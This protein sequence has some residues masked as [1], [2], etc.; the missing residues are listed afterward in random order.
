MYFIPKIEKVL[1][2]VCLSLFGLSVF[3][4]EAKSFS[5]GLLVEG[6]AN[7][8]L[9][10]GLA[11]GVIGEYSFTNHIAAG[12]K[13]D[14]GTDFNDV[15]VSSAELLGFGRYYF[16]TASRVSFF[17]QV[18]AGAIA[19]FEGNKRAYSVLGDG[20]LGIRIRIKN[21]YTDPYVRFGWPTG[22]GFGIAIGYRFGVK[23]PSEEEVQVVYLPPPV[24]QEPVEEDIPNQLEVFFIGNASTFEIIGNGGLDI[25]MENMAKLSI[26]A[27]FL[28]EN[29]EY[30]VVITGHANPVEGSEI[31]E[32]T[33]LIPLSWRRAEY[34]MNELNKLGIPDERL[35]TRGVGGS[36]N[37]MSTTSNRRVT[38]RFELVK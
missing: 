11:G 15:A 37:D 5:L 22:L 9:G 23:S 35:I 24:E 10:F 1:F 31:E 6:N 32:Q 36:E 16:N 21:F 2:A 34:I 33:R 14:Y 8:R 38:F 7:T 30:K 4:Q 20:A 28:A 26:I 19:L 12:L 29:P 18:G 17:A 25:F 3:G 27:S 13:A